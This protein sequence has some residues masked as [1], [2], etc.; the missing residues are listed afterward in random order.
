MPFNSI[1]SWLIQKR[2]HSID[3]FKCNPSI[4]QTNLREKLVISNTETLFG[5]RH[6]FTL[7][8]SYEDFSNN[9]GLNDYE[10]LLPYIEK[11]IQGEKNVL[12]KGAT[13]WFSKSSGTTSNRTKLIPVTKSSLYDCHYKGGKD[14]LA[15]YYNNYPNRKLYKGKHLILGGST[16]INHINH[17]SYIG[18]LS[19]IIVKNLPW[20]AEIRRSPSKSTTL[21]SDWEI[22][23]EQMARETM[24]QDIYILAGVPSWM[25]VLCKKVLEI[26][27]KNHLREVWPNLELFM[28]G[29]VSFAPYKSEFNQL[30]PYSDMHY[31]ETYN[32]S[33][34]FFGI[35][36][37]PN[38]TDLLLM[39]DYGIFYEFI[40]MSEFNGTNSSKVI[41]LEEI[42]IGVNYALVITT[43]GGLWR[44]IIGDTVQFTSISPY[45]FTITGR[46][47][48]FINVFGEE[49]IVSNS[50]TAIAHACSVSNVT[51]T[52]YTVGPIFIENNQKGAHEWIIELSA[53]DQF[54]ESKFKVELDKK[55]K[56]V[57]SDYAA[58]RSFDLL[59]QEPVIHFVPN[60]TFE[61]W[62]KK[63][64]K[65]G[66]QN[67]IPRL[68]N[69][70]K[71]LQEILSCVN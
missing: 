63:N 68:S 30:L 58:K 28:H 31:I 15:I 53:R 70:R 2:V 7:I 46:T 10:S 6:S 36:D 54:D 64:N 52:E 51:L 60:G 65:L 20:W 21:L 8:N 11:E 47:Q 34:G 49:I 67:K 41:P 38:S 59:L 25:L 40:P 18:D 17:Y 44:Y 43:N 57:N 39:L 27:G 66:G 61:R 62:Y 9:I 24:T 48:S 3:Y 1:F 14:L 29:G 71:L 19:A 5:N 69:D 33:E 22:K 37:D 26:S 13:K 16:E 55:L 4:V 56:D 50:D 45:K 35:Q 32:S 23:L 42:K 12:T